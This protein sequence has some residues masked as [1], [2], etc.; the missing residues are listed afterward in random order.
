[1]TISLIAAMSRER[2]IGANN[3]MLWHL[4]KELA[5]F[6]RTTLNKTVVMGRKTYES[7]GRPLPNRRNVIL[8]RQQDLHIEG[9]E[10]VHTV[11]EAL[12]KYGDE[13]LMITG[14]GEIYELFL[15]IADR[16]YLTKVEVDIAHADAYFPEFDEQEFTLTSSEFVESDEKN[17]YSF[18]ICVYDR[19]K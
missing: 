1:M 11:E 2:A 17:K 7:L 13:E 5:H 6:K 3:Q 15:P 14:G 4:P 9:C 18:T 12:Q 16:L 10:I 19:V 8:T